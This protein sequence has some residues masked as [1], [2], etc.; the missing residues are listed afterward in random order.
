MDWFVVF[1]GIEA[2]SAFRVSFV[3]AA[4]QKVNRLHFVR[5]YY[6][7][8]AMQSAERSAVV[9][10]FARYVKHIKAVIVAVYA[11][12]FHTSDSIFLACS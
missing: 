2:T 11:D 4:V 10:V 7:R 8:T 1:L 5:I 9:V 3:S 12:W 6:F